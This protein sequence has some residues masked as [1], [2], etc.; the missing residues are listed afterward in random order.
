M[1]LGAVLEP[2]VVVTLLFGGSFF[3]RNKDYSIAKGKSTYAGNKNH[4]R[5]D[6]LGRKLSSDSLMSGYS[7]SPTLAA[8]EV[9]TLRR[10]KF[11]LFG[12]KRIV[13]TPNT[14]VFKDRL[15]S[16]LLQKFPFLVEA[17]YWLQ[18][19]W[20]SLAQ[21][22]QHF[23]ACRALTALSTGLPGRPCH[24]RSDSRRGHSQRR[25]SPCSS[26]HSH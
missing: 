23:K 10:R 11:Q 17:W 1:G 16:R 9:P 26:T 2:L 13:T 12:Y 22:I 14:M 24:H 18:I 20:V 5:S 8:H 21:V 7:S 3:N 19:Y 4:K 25:P 6:D 15:L